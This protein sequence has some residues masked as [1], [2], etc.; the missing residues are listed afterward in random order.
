MLTTS[1]PKQPDPL[2][3]DKLRVHDK[4]TDTSVDLISVGRT[5]IEVNVQKGDPDDDDGDVTRT[6]HVFLIAEPETPPDFYAERAAVVSALVEAAKAKGWD[7]YWWIDIEAPSYPVVCIELPTGSVTWH[8]AAYD[9]ERR[10]DLPER[11]PAYDGH[12]TAEKYRR[13]AA[14]DWHS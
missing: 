1:E 2:R 7:C 8:I 5:I 4:D 6:R 14:C 11:L 10:F 9:F 13:L 12:D 3:G